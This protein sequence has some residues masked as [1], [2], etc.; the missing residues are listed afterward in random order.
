MR[1]FPAEEYASR[2]DR[3]QAALAAADL[4][5]VLLTETANFEY[6]TGYVV[7][8]MWSSMTRIL[9]VYVPASGRPI[10]LVPRFVA[11]VA[12]QAPEEFTSVS[13]APGR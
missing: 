1:P 12:S 3:I 2:L 7:R 13:R 9:A 8:V 5:G 11:E 4:D 6:V 10:L